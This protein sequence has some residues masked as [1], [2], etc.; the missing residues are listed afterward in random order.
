MIYMALVELAEREGL[1]VDPAYEPVEVHYLV[2]V[3]EGGRYLGCEAPRN[4]LPSG[5]PK[6]IRARP[7]RRSIPRRSNRTSAPHA[8]FLVD[9]AE[10]VFGIDPATK[11]PEKQLTE[12]R[13]LFRERIAKALVKLPHK[14]SLKALHAFLGRDAP[15]D[16]RKLL[17]AES[18]TE[19]VALSGALFAFLYEPD[20]GTLCVHDDPEVKSYFTQVLEDESG[21]EKGQCLVTG[22]TD[23]ALSRLHARPKGIPP[24]KETG[25]GV[26]LTSFNEEA[27]RSYDLEPLGWAPISRR[28][29]LGIELAL[30]RLLDSEY[31]RPDGGVFDKQYAQIS[32]DTVI[33]YW[34]K[35]DASL[36]WMAELEHGGPERVGDLIRSPYKGRAAPLEDPS[37]FY[38]LV[39]SG[40]RG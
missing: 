7:P 39:L 20:G 16:I 9:K 27:F 37:I 3:G 26:P 31:P 35:E 24:R 8:E 1:L 14:L 17:V 4:E 38:A 33:V 30:D 23:V 25:G 6:R 22:L 19:R 12:R 34:S 36:G 40:S 29:N 10:Y 21:E 15:A 32:P 5:A 11:R 2:H 13:R 18:A 28:A